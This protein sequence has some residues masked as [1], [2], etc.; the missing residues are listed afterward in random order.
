[1]QGKICRRRNK[2]APKNKQKPNTPT[3]K[4][5][6]LRTYRF[7]Q[8]FCL[9]FLTFSF[10]FLVQTELLLRPLWREVKL[11]AKETNVHS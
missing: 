8:P 11:S 2:N 10:G 9:D 7:Y 4:L 3:L 1:M 5:K 6:I